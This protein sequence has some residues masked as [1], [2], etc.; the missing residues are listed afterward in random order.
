MILWLSWYTEK[1]LKCE[2][3]D[4]KV[5]FF[6]N[7]LSYLTLFM[8]K[9]HKRKTCVNI[10]VPTFQQFLSRCKI[11]K[12]FKSK[13]TTNSLFKYIQQRWVPILA[14][15]IIGNNW[16]HTSEFKRLKN[17]ALEKFLLY[18]VTCFPL[19]FTVGCFVWECWRGNLRVE[20]FRLCAWAANWDS[21]HRKQTET[22]GLW[23]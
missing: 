14:H 2:T 19:I 12:C 4:F 3:H 11:A 22:I 16:L 10:L 15:F 1:T 13:Q 20:K 7:K 9:S 5:S 8:E 6:K 17:F 23:Y 21:Y 18:L